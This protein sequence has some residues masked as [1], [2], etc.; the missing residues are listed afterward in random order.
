MSAP[1]AMTHPC[2]LQDVGG[3]RASRQA[4]RQGKW[5]RTESLNA[6]FRH[7]LPAHASPPEDHREC[8]V[9]IATVSGIGTRQLRSG[10]GRPNT[11]SSWRA[12]RMANLPAQQHHPGDGTREV[13]DVDIE[14]QWDQDSFP[15]DT[16]SKS[17]QPAPSSAAG[18][19]R[20]AAAR[21][22]PHNAVHCTPTQQHPEE[23]QGQPRCHTASYAEARPTRTAPAAPPSRS[24]LAPN[25]PR[26]Q[27]NL[28]YGQSF[29]TEASPPTRQPGTND[30][31]DTSTD[32]PSSSPNGMHNSETGLHAPG[33]SP[34]QPSP[35]KA[36]TA[37]HW[38]YRA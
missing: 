18:P 7:T 8:P 29:T 31:T 27:S 24:K 15:G 5:P 25:V 17:A 11:L 37:I 10:P 4:L 23:L 22:Q 35:G 19:D 3:M 33:L 2:V 1:R 6:L 20:K 28:A 26:Q 14:Q 32:Q 36:T 34:D 13:M 9:S 38:W 16:V 30:W 21:D 12:A